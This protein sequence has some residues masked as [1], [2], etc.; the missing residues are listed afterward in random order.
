MRTTG[1]FVVVTMNDS[2][3]EGSE[4]VSRLRRDSGIPVTMID[5]P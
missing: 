1:A 5:R 4:T 2:L 3:R